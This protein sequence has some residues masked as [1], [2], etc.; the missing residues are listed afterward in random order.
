VFVWDDRPLQG[1]YKILNFW[2]QPGTKFTYNITF[3][4]ANLI[5]RNEYPGLSPL[6]GAFHPRVYVNRIVAR[7]QNEEE[8]IPKTDYPDITVRMWP[9]SNNDLFHF[10]VR[11][12]IHEIAHTL[13]LLNP[14][15]LP[16]GTTGDWHYKFDTM[17]GYVMHHQEHWEERFGRNGDAKWTKFDKEFLLF[18]LPRPNP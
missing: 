5:D 3:G 14:R 1:D 11:T 8:L 16:V 13:G 12:A 10:I 7:M 18:V 4:Q 15:Q 17:R 9:Y 6:R 2:G